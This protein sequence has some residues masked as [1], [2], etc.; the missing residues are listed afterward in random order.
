MKKRLDQIFLVIAGLFFWAAAMIIGS[1]ILSKLF[2][3]AG[4][5]MGFGGI[6]WWLRDWIQTLDLPFENAEEPS[7]NAG[8]IDKDSKSEEG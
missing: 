3:I 1:F 6:I 8:S 2:V 7:N 4:F 5:V